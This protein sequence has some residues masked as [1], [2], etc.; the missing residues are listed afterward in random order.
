[1]RLQTAASA[2][3]RAAGR[4]AAA[5]VALDEDI[6]RKAKTLYVDEVQVLGVRN[7]MDIDEF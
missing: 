2:T 1:M 4:L 3:K 5:K 6:E 7:T